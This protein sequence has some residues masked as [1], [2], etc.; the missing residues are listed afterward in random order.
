MLKQTG[1]S[2]RAVWLLGCLA[3]SGVLAHYRVPCGPGEEGRHEQRP[4]V[5]K[6]RLAEP[7]ATTTC[8]AL[9]TSV[10][11]MPTELVKTLAWDQGSEMAGHAGFSLVSGVD[12]YF[13]HPHSPWECGTNE[14]E[15]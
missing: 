12:V 14:I 6:R 11:N 4:S 9:I 10:A 3:T 5:H 2:P 1:A 8:D 7:D 15:A 13:A